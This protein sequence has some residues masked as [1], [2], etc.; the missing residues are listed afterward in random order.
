MKDAVQ[1]PVASKDPEDKKK[2]QKADK[3]DGAPK[4]DSKTP[5]DDE[6]VRTTLL[7]KRS[8]E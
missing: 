4:D 2:D 3:A 5:N 8:L 1:I 6:L 7:H